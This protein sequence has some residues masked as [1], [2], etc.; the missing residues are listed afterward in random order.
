MKWYIITT[1][2]LYAIGSIQPFIRLYRNDYKKKV[3]KY[4]YP[5]YIDKAIK[6]AKMQDWVIIGKC[7][8]FGIFGMIVL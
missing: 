5:E 1:L 6:N 8:F 7:V 3:E 4:I 2:V